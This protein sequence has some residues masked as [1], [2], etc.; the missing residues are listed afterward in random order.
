MLAVAD[1]GVWEKATKGRAGKRWDIVV[2]KVWED[3]G[4]NQEEILSIHGVWGY[5][6]EVKERIDGRD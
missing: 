2:E 1:R 3:I 5:K 6:T 4:G